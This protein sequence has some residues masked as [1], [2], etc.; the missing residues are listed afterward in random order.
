[1]KRRI[2]GITA[3]L[4]VPIMMMS[5]GIISAFAKN[6]QNTDY[7][8]TKG[9]Y[10]Y[11][12]GLAEF[13][14]LP[15]STDYYVYSD[16]YF[17]NS[18]KEY[19]PCLATLSMQLC[20]ASVSSSREYPDAAGYKKMGRNAAAFME[21][22]GFTDIELNED[23]TLKPNK[24]SLG[25]ACAHKSIIDN[26]KKYTLLILIPRS[27]GYEA[28]WADNFVLGI[29]G[30]AE[31]FHVCSEKLLA[32]AREYM[33]K[34]GIS[35]DLKLWITGYSRGAAVVNIAAGRIMDDLKGSL[36]KSVSLDKDDIYAYTF[37]TP[38]AAYSGNDPKNE[39]YS[40]IFNLYCNTELP[41][42]LP[43]AEMGFER[44]GT[45]MMI[46]DKSRISE[47]EKNLQICSPEMYELYASG[48]K[49]DSFSPK[50][51]DLNGNTIIG[52]ADDPDSYIPSDMT[53]YLKGFSAYLTDYT[54]GRENYSKEFE[55]PVSD[56]LAYYNSLVY[57]DAD[58]FLNAVMENED[59]L[60]L[61]ASMYAYFMKTKYSDL[62]VSKKQAESAAK[63]L[64]AVTG[65]E[66]F[67]DNTVIDAL[68]AAKLSLAIIGF[69]LKEPGDIKA[70]AAGYLGNVL[71][72]AMKKTGASEEE[73]AALTDQSSLEAL[74][75]M[76]S[77][78]LFGNIWQ[79]DDVNL[80]DMNN[81]QIKN[82]A[83]LIG[84]FMNYSFFMDHF[85]ELIKAWL[86]TDD[87]NFDDYTVLSVPQINGYRRLY[88]NCDD[89][90]DVNGIIT[91]QD[92]QKIA[93]IK[94]G[95]LK[96]SSDSWLGFTTCDEGDFF[97]IPSD[98]Y[99][100][101]TLNATSDRKIRVKIDEYS[102]Y[103]A[104]AF[105]K[106]SRDIIITDN[107]TT[108]IIMPKSCDE[109]GNLTD[110]GYS[111]E[112]GEK[113]V[114]MIGDV[115]RDQSITVADATVIQSHLAR[116]VELDEIQMLLADTDDDKLVSI[117][118]VTDI[119]KYL[120]KLES[121]KRIGTFKDLLEQ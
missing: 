33:K 53:E 104:I 4:L 32:F 35:G 56:F 63:G 119:Q 109:T 95:V 55:G 62:N 58:A 75:H 118:D 105:E 44:Y 112:S 115:D 7:V 120:A 30:D 11:H 34:Y 82:A 50:K 100:K 91:D 23:Y 19:N 42:I 107:K 64:I 52:T 27:A 86:M 28:E 81:E 69:M 90:S 61:L 12:P 40:G 1:M 92:G 76:A 59:T 79:S 6:N 77:Y 41:S 2:A 31:G 97:R 5:S 49:S 121:S 43:P 36:G 38:L 37:G 103:D 9:V 24:D 20:E 114:Y 54:G 117:I 26:G 84:N 110:A 29:S 78:L 47:M 89:Q 22:I 66:A 98:I 21:D 87:A 25:I 15:D 71:T 13:K 94:N 111:V 3:F 96:S 73:T 17:K 88:L 10:Y 116:L 85:N 74:V 39:R 101:I 70:S 72:D 57:D 45:D 46:I 108:T 48:Y 65:A 113:R 106:F 83:T 8:Y 80:L 99:C 60:Y 67:Q 14:N 18:S 93:V 51:I 68:S 16:E 102:C